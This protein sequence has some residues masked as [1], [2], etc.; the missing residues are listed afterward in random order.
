MKDALAGF[1]HA[2]AARPKAGSSV[3]RTMNTASLFITVLSYH[4]RRDAVNQQNRK[5]VE[6]ITGP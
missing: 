3:K 5:I 2:R 6:G 1:A 4:D